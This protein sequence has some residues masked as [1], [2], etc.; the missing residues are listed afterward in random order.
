MLL[1]LSDYGVSLQKIENENV[2]DKLRYA[3]KYYPY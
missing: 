1:Q 2:L 3:F